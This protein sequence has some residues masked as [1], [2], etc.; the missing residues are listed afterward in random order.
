MDR[1]AKAYRTLGQ[2]AFEWF[3]AY[4]FASP[5]RTFWIGIVPLG[6]FR[7]KHSSTASILTTSVC[8]ALLLFV[9]KTSRAQEP[10]K[11]WQWQNPLPQGNSINS[12]KFASD[13]R[14]GWAV[15]GDGVILSTSDGGFEWDEEESRANTT[16]YSIYLKDRDHLVVSGARGT[17]LT[18]KNGGA[19]W[20]A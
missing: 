16:L 14:H 3:G 9:V 13:K 10:F 1:Q 5:N 19:K 11:G 15:G 2:L 4:N 12:I 20:V 18:T 17:I 8:C 6:L 7:T